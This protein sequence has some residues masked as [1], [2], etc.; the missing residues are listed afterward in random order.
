MSGEQLLQV[1]ETTTFVLRCMLLSMA[2]SGQLASEMRTLG[3]HSLRVGVSVIFLC[4][5]ICHAFRL[6]EEPSLGHVSPIDPLAQQSIQNVRY[7]MQ[8]SGSL[9]FLD[10]DVE[11]LDNFL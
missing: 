2:L 4:L 7:L 9:T 5:H 8:P 1:F 6:L 11:L 3:I 10:N